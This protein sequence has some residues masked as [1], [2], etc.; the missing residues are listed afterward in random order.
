MSAHKKKVSKHN[1]NP[2]AAQRK[3]VETNESTTKSQEL[4]KESFFALTGG[5]LKKVHEKTTKPAWEFL[6]GSF[7][8]VTDKIVERYNSERETME[9]MGFLRYVLNGVQRM[10]I[11][12]AKVGALV[13]LAVILDQVVI[14][15]MGFSFIDPTTV[16]IA[17]GIGLVAVIIESIVSQKAEGSDV[18]AR[19]ISSS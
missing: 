8:K 6:K 7:F 19:L 1:V 10:A 9:Q 4:K 2:Q 11:K 17:L 5:M 15:Y 16:L 14:N 18:S 3:K 12:I 13:T